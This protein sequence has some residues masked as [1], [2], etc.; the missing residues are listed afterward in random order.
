MNEARII[1]SRALVGILRERGRNRRSLTAIAGPPGAG[2]STLADELAAKLNEIEAG[3][4]AVLPADGYH[5]DNLVLQTK[6]WLP[7]KGAPH[8]FDVSGFASMLGR[9]RSNAEPSIAVPVFDRGIEIARNS[10]RLVP[11]GVRH[12]IV[13]G[14]YLLLEL[15]PWDAL[16][17][18]FDTTVFLEVPGNILVARLRERWTRLA[19]E[20]RNRKL[21]ENDLPNANLVTT[22]SRASEFVIRN[23]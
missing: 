22:R 11:G 21:D 6:G 10:A 23:H 19:P 4:A 15:P 17:A 9:I 14:N 16:E 2:K 3:C 18:F 7:R 20:E 13:E 8:T 12:V 1:D 5:Y